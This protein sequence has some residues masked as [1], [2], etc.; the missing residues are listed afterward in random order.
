MIESIANWRIG[1]IVW[2]TATERETVL[3]KST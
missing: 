2:S 1:T 3:Q